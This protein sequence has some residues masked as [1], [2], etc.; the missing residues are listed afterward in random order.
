MDVNGCIHEFVCVHVH[1]LEDVMFMLICACAG[2]IRRCKVHTHNTEQLYHRCTM[3]VQCKYLSDGLVCTE[4]I[5]QGVLL[6]GEVF[7]HHQEV[8]VG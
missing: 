5:R 8:E 6:A 4:K 7:H 3:C 1:I 2:W